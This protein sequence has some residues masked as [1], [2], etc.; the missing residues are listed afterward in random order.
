ML[1]SVILIGFIIYIIEGVPLKK[2]RQWK[3]LITVI[4]LIFIAI[5]LVGLKK[6]D[7]PNPINIL[8]NIIGP[9]GKKV[10]RT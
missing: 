7:M 6:L 2:K 8:E 10:F 9:V 5:F 1:T 3:E 4:L